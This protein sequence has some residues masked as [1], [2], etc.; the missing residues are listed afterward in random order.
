MEQPFTEQESIKLINEMIG[1]VKRSY[2]EKGIASIVWG[3]LIMICSMLTWARLQFNFNIG[4]DIWL[5]VFF[6][7]IPQIYFSN[8][9]LFFSEI[10]FCLPLTAKTICE[11]NWVY[12][13]GIFFEQN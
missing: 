10:K 5:L 4:F 2:V 7:V 8:S 12:V 3:V 1:K 9:F 11:Y 13:F 6:A